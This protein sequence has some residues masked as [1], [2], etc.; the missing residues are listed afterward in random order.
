MVVWSSFLLDEM[1]GLRNDALPTCPECK[2]DPAFLAKNSGIVTAITGPGRPAGAVR[3]DHLLGDRQDRRR[4]GERPQ[5][6]RVHDERGLHR[7]ARH[8]AR[9]QVPG[10]QGRPDR[11]PTSSPPP[12]TTCRPAWTPRS[13]SP[14]STRPTCSRSCRTSPDTFQR[15]GFPQ[16]QGA[17]RRRHARRA[18]RAQGDQRARPAASSTPPAAAKRAAED[19]RTIQKS[20]GVDGRH[21]ARHAAGGGARAAPPAGRG[22][23]PAD[24]RQRENRAGLAYLSPTLVV[25]LVVVVLPILWTVMLAFQRIR[26]INIRRAG[27]FGEYTLRQLRARCSPRRASGRRCGPRW[28]TRSAAPFLSILFGLVAALALRGRSAGARSCGPP[29]CC[30]TSRR[31]WR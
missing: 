6:R 24:P 17:L 16:G 19:V 3:R 9:G 30:R 31:W 21:T 14:R 18:A 27:L 8:R 11:P 23:A 12:G 2:A 7:L 29:C 1:A 22:T 28:S 5:V 25:V 26:L 10:P 13:R 4:H 20:L 15:W